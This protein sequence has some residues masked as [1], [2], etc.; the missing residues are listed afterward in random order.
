MRRSNRMAL[1]AAVLSV[2]IAWSPAVSG[3]VNELAS[4]STEG[5]LG[6]QDTYFSVISGDGGRVA[7]QSPASNLVPNDFNGRHDIFVRDFHRGVTELVSVNTSGNSGN[8]L[9]LEPAISGN[10]RFVVFQSNA[11]DLVPNDRNGT[12]DIFVRDLDSGVTERV[13]L[14]STGGEANDRSDSPDISPNGRF[15]VFHSRAALVPEDTNGAYDIY[16]LDRQSGSLVR[17][18]VD[19]N[20]LQANGGSIWPEVSDDGRFVVFQ[21]DATNLVTPDTNGWGDV[22]V[23]DLQSGTIIRCNQSTAG[24]QSNGET[25]WPSISGDGSIIT[26]CTRGGTLVP[27]DTNNNWDAFAHDRVTRETVRINV[28]PNGSQADSYVRS[29]TALTTDGRLVAFASLSTNLVPD[30]TNGYQDI[31]VRD[32]VS[33]TTIRI[34]FGY[35]RDEADD[36]SFVP[37]IADDGRFVTFTSD[38]SNLTPIDTNGRQDIFRVDLEAGAL[39]TQDRLE[40]GQLAEFRV[41]SLTPGDEVY[42]GYSLNGIGDGRCFGALGGLCLDLLNP[43]EVFAFSRAGA[44]GVATASRT[45]PSN[46]SITLIHTQAVIDRGADSFKTNSTSAPVI[47]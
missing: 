26:F 15:V 46:A 5:V 39:F 2:G 24:V 40:R 8:D 25:T 9:S 16:R 18:S 33:E 1:S 37:S 7:F 10:G 34:N 20:G 17:V 6:N 41:F 36:D 27:G 35:E 3:Q 13:S 44:D 21:S 12:W 45:V 22:F 32:L 31:F 43:I 47:P 23:K 19:S 29:P 28:Q 4:Q 42:F 38:A 30:D 14:T 11:S